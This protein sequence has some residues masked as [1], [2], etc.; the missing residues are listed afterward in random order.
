MNARRFACEEKFLA[1]HYI[2]AKAVLTAGLSPCLRVLNIHL[3]VGTQCHLLPDRSSC[4]LQ[5]YAVK[6]RT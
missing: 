3:Y 2:E 5:F 4:L 6:N 1:S